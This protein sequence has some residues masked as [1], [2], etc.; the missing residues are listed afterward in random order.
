MLG[1][2]YLLRKALEEAG[3]QMEQLHPAIK[4]PGST[5]GPF[6]RLRL[7]EDGSIAALEPIQKEEEAG[8]WTHMDGNQNSFPVLR[9]K[10]PLLLLPEGHRFSWQSSKGEKSKK[11]EKTKYRSEMLSMVALCKPNTAMTT[12]LELFERINVGKSILLAEAA[13]RANLVDVAAV[14]RG[15]RTAL[16]KTS[17]LEDS[18]AII[19]DLRKCAVGMIEVCDT[20]FLD[21]LELLLFTPAP[22]SSRELRRPAQL[23]FD[24]SNPDSKMYRSSTRLAISRAML[25]G[26][27]SSNSSISLKH[28]DDSIH[29]AYTGVNGGK[30]YTNPFPKVKLP[31]I[32]EKGASL[33]TM[34]SAATCNER[35]GNKDNSLMPVSNDLVLKM[36]DALGYIVLPESEGKT[37]RSIAGKK[38]DTPDLLIVYVDGSPI[39]DAKVADLFGSDEDTLAQQYDVDVQTVCDALKGIVKLKPDSVLNLFVIRKASEGQA[40]VTLVETPSV[41][42]VLQGAV[43]WQKASLNIPRI[44]VPI[45]VKKLIEPHSP[46]TPSPSQVVALMTQ[47]WGPRNGQ[48]Q[49]AKL[50]GVA[51]GDVLNLML[52]RPHQSQNTA[53]RVLNT[54]VRERGALL[55]GI[56]GCKNN[57][58]W[59][60]KYSDTTRKTALR[61]ISVLG[62]CLFALDSKKEDYMKNGGFLIGQMLSLA[63]RLHHCYCE[64]VRGGDHPPTLIGNA[65]FDAALENPEQA[66][67]TLAAR[68]RIYIAWATT[69]FVSDPKLDDD[70]KTKNRRWAALSAKSVMKKFK[71]LALAASEN[72]P[73]ECDDCMRAQML[74]GYLA[75][76]ES[77]ENTEG[78]SR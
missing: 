46:R 40:F 12:T 56:G 75:S 22:T 1:E 53:C 15:F 52:Q 74:L 71:P 20:D 18:T 36:Q 2:I 68:M 9:L 64:V 78:E 49:D 3:I 28:S 55:A 33:F 43:W 62:I 39:I 44:T 77:E 65:I 41:N 57:K 60:G 54:L 34:N 17:E 31:L 35:Y 66:L 23:A 19:C 25:E 48:I 30:L 8:L 58:A 63:D 72:L 61:T 21:F 70:Q 7:S 76:V 10:E 27:D 5:T 59:W 14:C 42:E 29:C 67:S 6:G 16:S 37:W 24:T 32:A 38:P 73:K 51:F 69:V 50:R 13:E 4:V 11:V 26:E 45:P 47:I